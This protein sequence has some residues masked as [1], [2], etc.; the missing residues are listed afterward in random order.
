[1]PITTSE[2]VIRVA[3]E[4][5]V[6]TARKLRARAGGKFP[7]EAVRA[8]ID[9]FVSGEDQVPIRRE[10]LDEICSILGLQ[11]INSEAQ[12]VEAIRKNKGTRHGT[13]TVALEP[14]AGPVMCDV[15]HSNGIPL[16]QVVSNYLTLGII[17]GWWN[18]YC[19]LRGYLFNP[20]QHDR[21]KAAMKGTMVTADNIIHLL[22]ELRLL[23]EQAVAPAGVTEA[24]AA[25]K[26]SPEFPQGL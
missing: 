20:R 8:A 17:N 10:A 5:D 11:A 3:L 22:E 12:L 23:R 6:P 24:L 19:D 26:A 7:A 25:P 21:L 18:E 15:A 16:A 14:A 2:P 1:M 13:V 9:F 4:V